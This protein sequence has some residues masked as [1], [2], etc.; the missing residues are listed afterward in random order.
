MFYRAHGLLIASDVPL[1]LPSA[2][3]GSPDLVLHRAETR[4]VPPERPPGV[5]LA[6]IARPDRTL[7]YTLAKTD[8]S[9]VLRYPGLCDF[10]GDAEFARVSVHLH[11]GA[12]EGLLPVLIAGALLA[13]HLML[14]NR[15]VLHASAVQVDDHAVAFVGKSGMGKSTLATALCAEGYP[16]ISDDLLRVDAELLVHPGA[17]ETRLRPAAR[18][19]AGEAGYETADGRLALTPGLVAADPLPLATCVIPGPTRDATDVTVRRL[20]PVEALVRLSSY[21]RVLGW[22]DKPT[23][24]AAFQ[25]L[26]DLVE[27]IPVVE[28][29]IPWGPPFAPNVLTNLVAAVAEDRAVASHGRAQ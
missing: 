9:I 2:S 19:L 10:V 5:R 16:L 7:F 28:A 25:A 15:L 17:T 22:T 6:E 14:H 26:A 11:P 12:D 21:P 13:I 29:I 23:M 18:E 24:A 20:R 1:P 4:E 27:R 8:E 3:F